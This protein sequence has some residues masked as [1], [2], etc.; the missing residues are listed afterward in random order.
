MPFISDPDARTTVDPVRHMRLA[1][2]GRDGG[3]SGYMGFVLKKPDGDFHFAAL[4]ADAAVLPGG[5]RDSRATDLVWI[6]WSMGLLEQP[7]YEPLKEVIREAML[8]Y[9]HGCGLTQ[10]ELTYQVHFE[11]IGEMSHG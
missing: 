4:L 11:Q 1:R 2:D 3:S 9:K 10:P 6:V 7:L 5:P 8:S